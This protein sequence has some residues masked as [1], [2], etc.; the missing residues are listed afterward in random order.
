GA[1]RSDKAALG[2]LLEVIN[3]GKVPRGSFLVIENL[4]RL[5]REDE[6]TALR[7]W[8]DIL[9]AGI[10]IVQLHPETIF[11]HEKSDLVDIMRAIIELSRGHS[12]SRMKSV[13]TL[14]NWDTAIRRAREEGRTMTS[15]LPGW[16]E[17]VR[18]GL[19]L[20]PERAAVVQRIFAM[21]RAGYGMTSIAK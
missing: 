6:R 20:I 1:H 14:G 13:R 9:D 11:R 15:R 2:Q 4:D 3:E 5:S 12:E 10:N 18:G 8:L 17:V 16:V 21:A 7:L 19:R